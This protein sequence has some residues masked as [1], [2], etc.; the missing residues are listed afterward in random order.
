MAQMHGTIERPL[1]ETATEIR[2]VAAEQGWAIS[3]H[4][5]VP[6]QL[7]FTKGMSAFSWGSKL[8]AA[9]TASTPTETGIQINTKETFSL[10]DW[11]RGKRQAVKLLEDVGAELI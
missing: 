11:G 8:T 10:A 5:S 2:R 1:D 6:Q 7:V 3:E 9:L 4:E